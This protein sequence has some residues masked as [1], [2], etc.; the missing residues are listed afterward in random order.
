MSKRTETGKT[1][2]RAPEG[3][4]NFG[5]RG[6]EEGR[7]QGNGGERGGERGG[8]EKSNVTASAAGLTSKGGRGGGER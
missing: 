2:T 3:T 6:G 1:E 4:G 8:I 7:L 5:C